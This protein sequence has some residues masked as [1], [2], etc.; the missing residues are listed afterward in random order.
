MI[1]LLQP[2]LDVDDSGDG[3]ILGVTLQHARCG[4]DLLLQY[5]RMY[6]AVYQSPVQLFFVAHI[7]D[8]LIRCDS[9][10]EST[11]EVARFCLETLQD[12][13]ISY[14]LAGPLQRM[15][16]LAIVE[17]GVALSDDLTQL[18]KSISQFGPEDMLEACTR[19]TYQQP[20]KQIL[21][22]LNPGIARDFSHIRKHTPDGHPPEAEGDDASSGKQLRMQI[23]S[24][25]NS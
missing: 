19:I 2:L 21:S 16:C 9:D 5:S 1:N 6:S 20:S 8:T 13:R 23:K 22:N 15:F 7:C 18:A 3:F 17:Y 11:P 14:A 4:A 10:S 25:L 24:L 12:A